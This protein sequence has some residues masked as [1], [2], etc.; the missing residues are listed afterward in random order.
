MKKVLLSILM[1]TVLMQ[2]CSKD[3]E[4]GPKGDKGDQGVS[5]TPGVN[6]SIIYS[7]SGEP[8]IK[9]GKEG[10]F[11]LDIQSGK[12]YGAKTKDSWGQSFLM[13]G[14]KGDSGEDGTN[15]KD[16]KDG[17]DGIDGIDGIDG[18]DGID[19]IDGT[20]GID[21][22]N[23]TEIL[24]GNKAPD[25]NIGKIGDYFFDKSN[26]LLYGPKSIYSWGD[27]V[28]LRS[29]SELG[30]KAILYKDLQILEP[31][32]LQTAYDVTRPYFYYKKAF[33]LNNIDLFKGITFIYWNFV[34][35]NNQFEELTHE[36]FSRFQ[37]IESTINGT[38]VQHTDVEG[39]NN[40][41]F[42]LDISGATYL[43]ILL[44]GEARNI[45]GS[46]SSAN[47]FNNFINSAK[48][49]VLIKHLPYSSVEIMKASN[50]DINN[51]EQVK[52]FLRQ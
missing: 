23:G 5:G 34:D 43:T 38:K 45:D 14:E 35:P 44:V 4:I 39:L 47:D 30:A 9:I 12:L 8:D 18:K 15:G 21:G 17:K 51:S 2:G 10:D 40:Y 24:N 42:R 20:D 50:I 1:M 29:S 32:G 7:G 6:G 11:Y 36:N 28:S 31:S 13:K 49:N 16:G 52:R 41:N 22:I 27:P 19:G 37:W 33:Y 48:F 26:A 3:G 25:L 46:P